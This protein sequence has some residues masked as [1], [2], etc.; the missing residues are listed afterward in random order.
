MRI[1]KQYSPTELKDFRRKLSALKKQGLIGGKTVDVRSAKPNMLRGGKFLE[2]YIKKYDDVLSGKATAVPLAKLENRGRQRKLYETVSAGGIQPHVIVPHVKEESVSVS[3]GL[4]KIS[5][6]KGINRIEIPIDYNNLNQYLKDLRKAEK[7]GKLPELKGPHYYAFN[8]KGGQSHV[9]F[10]NIDEL[11]NYLKNPK[12]NVSGSQR[13]VNRVLRSKDPK[14]QR[15]LFRNLEIVQTT[16]PAWWNTK[17]KRDAARAD[18]KR[19]AK[20]KR[21]AVARKKA[22]EAKK[23]S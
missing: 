12:D 16:Q 2:E 13:W 11:V 7:S 18:E 23:K 22:R 9:I 1:G 5:H 17:Q 10:R 19:I 4:V 14:E 20:N 6:P 15:D 3:G 21:R 8:L